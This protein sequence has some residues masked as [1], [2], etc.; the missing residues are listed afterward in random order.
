MCANTYGLQMVDPDG[1]GFGDAHGDG[2]GDGIGYQHGR[3]DGC[4]WGNPLLLMFD[5]QVKFWLSLAGQGFGFGYG[6]SR[7]DGSGLANSI[8]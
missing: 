1:A 4:G 3:A 5:S 8:P 6:L 2:Y 7:L